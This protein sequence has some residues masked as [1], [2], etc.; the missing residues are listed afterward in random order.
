MEFYRENE[1]VDLPDGNEMRLLFDRGELSLAILTVDGDSL[2]ID[3]E[4]ACALMR[5]LAKAL[6]PH[7]PEV[8][9]V[10]GLSR[11]VVAWPDEDER[12]DIIGQNGN[13]GSHYK[14]GNEGND[15]GNSG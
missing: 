5:E 12:I 2:E 10:D 6:V 14:N 1:T 9:K 11:G 15:D 13:D 8:E 3:H 4:M 7:S